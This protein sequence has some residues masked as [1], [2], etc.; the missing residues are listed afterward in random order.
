MVHHIAL[1]SEPTV[2]SLICGRA[3][4]RTLTGGNLY[5]YFMFYRQNSLKIDPVQIK[6]SR[7][8][9]LYMVSEK[10]LISLK[11]KFAVL[12]IRLLQNISNK[13]TITGLTT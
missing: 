7:V 4:A 2:Y 10:K 11:C 3:V 9:V 6:A 8:G 13:C 12:E 5:S 1:L